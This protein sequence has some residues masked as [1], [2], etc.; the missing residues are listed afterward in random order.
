MQS[1]LVPAL[2]VDAHGNRLGQGGGWY[3]RMLPLVN[4]GVETFALL[5]PNEYLTDTTL[6]TAEF[7]RPVSGIITT[8]G[9]TRF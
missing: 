9:I 5:H 2:A 8:E 3:D 4:P 6:P 7:D 1:V